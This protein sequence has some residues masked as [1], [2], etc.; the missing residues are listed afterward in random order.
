MPALQYFHC[1]WEMQTVDLNADGKVDLVLPNI[2]QNQY[3]PLS[4]RFSLSYDEKSGTWESQ[5][6]TV[7]LASVT[8]TQAA[9]HPRPGF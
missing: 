6:I 2:A 4:T 3:I 1:A 7:T 5:F 9:L 8:P